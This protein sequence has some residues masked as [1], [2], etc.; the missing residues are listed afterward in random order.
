MFLSSGF[1]ADFLAVLSDRIARAFNTLT[2]LVLLAQKNMI[3]ARLL[4]EL[5]V[6]DF[7]SSFFSDKHLSV[8]K[9]PIEAV[10]LQD[11]ILVL[12][13]SVVPTIH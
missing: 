6:L 8:T 9:C 4:T 12:G 3:Y 13:F 2:R 5:E 11:V 1:L 7:I 10:I